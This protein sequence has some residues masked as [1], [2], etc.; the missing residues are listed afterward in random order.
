MIVNGVVTVVANSTGHLGLLETFTLGRIVRS[1]NMEYTTDCHRELIFT[2]LA[3]H[4]VREQQM[5]DLP[6]SI[7]DLIL[8]LLEPGLNVKSNLGI[9]ER[10]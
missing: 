3:S 2:G 7:S 10:S 9:T 6:I 8:E 1:G 5:P 4:L